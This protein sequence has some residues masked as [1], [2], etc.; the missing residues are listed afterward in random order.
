M[1]D[2]WGCGTARVSVPEERRRGTGVHEQERRWDR[3]GDNYG[4]GGGMT[5][6]E[7]VVNAARG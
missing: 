7:L 1:C 2:S 3:D 4:H 6:R 5:R